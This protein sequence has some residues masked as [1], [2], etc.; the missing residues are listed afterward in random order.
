[1]RLFHPRYFLHVGVLALALAV[2][3]AVAPL[4]AG[5]REV[6]EPLLNRAVVQNGVVVAAVAIAFAVLV[7]EA[8]IG[9]DSRSRV[10]R[11]EVGYDPAD[12]S[13]SG[14]LVGG[15][16]DRV[17][18]DLDRTVAAVD[19]TVSSRARVRREASVLPPLREAAISAVARS[20]GISR[21]AAA[22]RVA[23]GTWTDD[24]RAAALLADEGA[25]PLPLSVRIVDWFHGDAFERSVDA[26]LAEVAARAGVETEVRAP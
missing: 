12:A 26:T 7:T 25:A 2:V 14:S 8:E 9:S 3:A 17:G 5:V 19:R 10:D 15:G 6:V 22:E 11:D 13:V 24:E 16:G 20:E 23:E 1:M 21:T 4:P 18:A